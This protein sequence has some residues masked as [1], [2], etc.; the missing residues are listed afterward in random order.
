LLLWVHVNCHTELAQSVVDVGSVPL[1]ILCVQEPEI[2]LKRISASSLSDIS[3][4][5][6][7]LAQ[8]VVDAGAIAY[9]VQLVNSDD[10]KLKRQVFSALA[11]VKQDP[12]FTISILQ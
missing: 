9:L 4:H 10:A 7:E 2:S 11:Q 6:P 1:L 8:T 3:K 5:S 12:S